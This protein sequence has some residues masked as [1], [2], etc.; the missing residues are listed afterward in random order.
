[1]KYFEQEWQKMLNGEVYDAVHPE[2]I[3]RLEL[4]RDKLHRFNT[5]PPSASEERDAI[6]RGLLGRCG[7]RVH[8]NQPFRCDYGCNISVG[9]NFFANFNLTVLDEGPVTI[10]DNAFIGPNVSIYTACHPLD[11]NERNKGVQWAKPVTIGDD[12]WIGGGVTIVP[13]VTIGRGA[14]VA[15]GAVVT[16]DVP[17][18]VLV[19]GNPARIIKGLF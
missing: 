14:V 16:K 6:L 10:G 8:V 13:G 2:F 4:V 19:G 7:K 3:R 15:A 12:V 18:F 11:A 17:E 5:L 1:M 9:E